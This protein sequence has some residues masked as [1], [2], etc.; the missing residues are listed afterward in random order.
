[1]QDLPAHHLP[2][3]P[4]FI[5][6]N[7]T[8]NPLL[9]KQQ[10]SI[11]DIDWKSFDQRT[12]WEQEF[13]LRGIRNLYRE[14]SLDQTEINMMEGLFPDWRWEDSKEDITRMLARIIEYVEKH[15]EL[16][17]KNSKDDRNN[18]HWWISSYAN[19]LV[20]VDGE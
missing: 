19:H 1:L 11:E 12:E 14:G 6:T 18:I 9:E 7:E 13:I 15:G 5:S 8:G 10:V 4:I 2:A 3:H 16:P 17:G 20:E